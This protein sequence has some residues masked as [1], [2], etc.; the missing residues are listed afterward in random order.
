MVPSEG[1]KPFAL[2][3]IALLPAAPVLLGAGGAAAVDPIL[4][5]C[6]AHTSFSDG[7][8]L[9]GDYRCAGL[10]IPFHTS[11]VTASPSPLW[12]GQWLFVDERGR[13]RRGTCTFNR[14]T[15]PTVLVPS[16]VVPQV[17]PNDP[18]GA[19]GAYLA[20]RYGETTDPMV[21]AGLWAVF[22]HY[23]LDAAGSH[24]SSNPSAALVPRLDGIAA[25]SGRADL[26]A[27]AIALD[28][29]ARR[30]SGPW[31]LDVRL[32]QGDGDGTVVVTLRAGDQ[33]VTGRTVMVL[34]SGDDVSRTATTGTDGRA[35]VVVPI[36]SGTT[37]VAATTEA[38][39]PVLVY[40]G[41]P[42]APN[43]L[44]A[45]TLVV[46]GPHRVLRATT[47]LEVAPTT[48]PPMTAPPTTTPAT[49]IAPATT[50][51]PTTTVAP[52]TTATTTTAAPTTTAASTTTAAP[53]TTLPEIAV[54]TTTVPGTTMP[55]TTS[56][57]T[58]APTSTAPASHPPLPTTG[59]GG[60]GAI[61]QYA[62]AFLVGGI[63]LLGTLR[64]RARSPRS[65]P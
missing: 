9:A 44:G 3:A 28:A 41:T 5:G 43:P 65:A 24:R 15:H 22:H 58:V 49:T 6:V 34:V 30:M 12:A 37:T 51:A 40:R 54:P 64:R 33:P 38:P 46:A 14:G 53:T 10:A 48:T 36:P 50:T 2:A 60:D 11:G 18:T 20:W 55:G 32:T 27:R 17:F 42:A 31:T 63:G 26:Q 13:Q 56:P 29:E 47:T 61:A 35:T 62:T 8:D 57:V 21:A 19:K 52:S 25:A 4:A 7:G 16:R 39:G 1:V 23:A 59:R 45:Q